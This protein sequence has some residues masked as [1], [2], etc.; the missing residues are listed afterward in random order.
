MDFFLGTLGGEKKLKGNR[1]NLGQYC[2]LYCM[3]N[4]NYD[5]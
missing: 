3:V 4:E 5:T 2:Q 1:L